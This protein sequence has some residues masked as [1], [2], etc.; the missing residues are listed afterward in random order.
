MLDFI[1][2][3]NDMLQ[4]TAT[5]GGILLLLLIEPFFPRRRGAKGQAKRR[6]NNIGLALLNFFILGYFGV[7]YA[8]TGIASILQPVTPLFDYLQL[9][10]AVS[11]IATVFCVELLGYWFHR[12]MHR[13]PLLW[14][15][16]AVHHNDTEIDVTT[17]NRHHPFEGMIFIV[18]TF[19]LMIWLGMPVIAAISYNAIHLLLSLLTHAN[20]RLPER[21]DNILRLFVVT[22]DFHRMHH[23]SDRQYTD[24]NYGMITP[25]FDYLFGTASRIP[26]KEI[27]NMEIGLHY[28]RKP[29]ESRIDRLLLQPFVWRK[30]SGENKVVKTIKR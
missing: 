23:S 8:S 18:L 3:N 12:A 14:R 19:P 17:T 22:P 11:I 16:H 29:R 5:F 10:L 6:V 28:L 15:I 4:F 24:S 9:P 30:A 25:W 2:K 1:L 26:Y 20:I 13:V 7:A 21:L 27:P